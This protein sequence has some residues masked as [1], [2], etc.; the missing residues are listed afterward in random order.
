MK[1]CSINQAQLSGGILAG[2]SLL[3]RF[4]AVEST[5][6]SDAAFDNVK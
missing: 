5:Q 2:V 1:N 4:H 3:L 6:T